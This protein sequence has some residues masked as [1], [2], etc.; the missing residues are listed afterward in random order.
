MIIVE[1]GGT[2]P[3]T[4]QKHVRGLTRSVYAVAAVSKSRSLKNTD[5]IAKGE[6]MNTIARRERGGGESSFYAPHVRPLVC[7]FTDFSPSLSS[8]GKSR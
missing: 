5:R 4:F 8:G 6:T 1:M 3:R 2:N 7:S